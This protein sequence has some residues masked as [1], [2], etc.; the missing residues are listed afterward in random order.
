MSEEKDYVLGTHDDEISRLGLQH[1]IW[2]PRALDAWQRAGITVGQTVID[3]GCGP[4]YASIDLAEIAGAN[5]KVIAIDRS[6]RFLDSLES[7]CRAREIHNVITHELDLNEA[8]LPDAAAD[9]AWARWIFAFVKHPRLLLERASQCIKRGGVMVIH[10]YFH[11]STWQ[12]MPR[13]AE[14]EEF[15]T[16]V[17]KSWRDDGGEP[18]IAM[19]LPQWLNELGFEIKTLNPIIEIVSPSDY[20]WHWP[21]AF[22]RTGIDRLAQLGAFTRA[23]ADEIMAA[24]A[25]RASDSNAL[26]VTPGVLEIIAIRK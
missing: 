7:R 9:A 20:L 1:S 12:M 2:R 17:M 18:D 10:E 6:R 19:N 4:G 5:G 15:V 26:M 16:A 8:Q 21:Q 13:C 24:I 25:A 3:I 23:R 11:Y 14:L 22:L